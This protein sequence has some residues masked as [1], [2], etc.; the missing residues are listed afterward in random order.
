[1]SRKEYYQANKEEI[2][3]KAR[4]YYHANKE[5]TLSNVKKYRDENRQLIQEKGREYYRRRLKN[6]L[7]NSAR[8]RSRTHGYEFDLTEDDFI[9]PEYCP[10]LGIKMVVNERGT[11]KMDSF[12]LDR[13]DSSKGYVKG[14]V[15]VISMLANSMKSSAT[16]EQFQMMAQKWTEWKDKNY[17]ISGLPE[18]KS[19]YNDEN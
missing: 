6:R 3:Q 17:D 19:D 13:I 5:K 16:Y 9:I 12:S 1:M 14:N 2:K 4:D 18:R 11:T 15:W 10:L 8:A 7:V